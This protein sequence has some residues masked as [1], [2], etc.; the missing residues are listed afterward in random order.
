MEKNKGKVPKI[1]FPGFTDDWE[2]R[3]FEN[4]ATRA[5]EMG[6]DL[7]LPRVEYEDIIQGLGN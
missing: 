4:I 5:S 6:S 7:Y 3:K 2:Q 1:R